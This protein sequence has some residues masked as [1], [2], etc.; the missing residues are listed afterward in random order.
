[1]G[2][3]KREVPPG[4]QFGTALTERL[5]EDGDGVRASDESPRRVLRA[6]QGEQGMR[7]FSRIAALVP[8]HCRG[9]FSGFAGGRRVRVDD[10]LRIHDRVATEKLRAEEVP[11]R[12]A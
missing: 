5:L 11:V 10:A 12:R 1:M 8:V 6:S 4:F 3:R 7:E 9:H 2:K